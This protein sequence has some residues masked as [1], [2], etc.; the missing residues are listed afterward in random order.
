MLSWLQRWGA[1]V[2]GVQVSRPAAEAAA[3]RIG[4]QRVFVGELAEAA[5]PDAWFDCVTLWHVLEHVPDPVA[6]LREIRRVMKPDGVVYV[7][8]PNAG[9]WS[10][11][12][13]GRHWL[14]LDVPKHLVH[15]TPVSLL[16]VASQ[17]EL[18]CVETRHMSWEYSPVTLLQ[19]LLIAWLG[20]DH[21]LF[22]SLSYEPSGATRMSSRRILHLGLAL[23]CAIPAAI[24]SRLLAVAKC[25]DALVAFFKVNPEASR[26]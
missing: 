19:S 12:V 25:G 10:A 16:A 1:E 17:A 23:V 18:R 11:G 8:V 7:E 13:F 4:A 14:G 22:R 3:Q 24:V 15:F 9:G 20:G 2:Y 6:L 21:L 5:Y 26:V